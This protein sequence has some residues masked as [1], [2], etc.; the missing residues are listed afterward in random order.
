MLALYNA[1]IHSQSSKYPHATALLIHQGRILAMG[2]DDEVLSMIGGKFTSQNME[3][4]TIWPGLT[5]AHLHLQHYALGLQEVP[6]ETD[7]LEECLQN[8]AH[9]AESTEP[10]KWITGW[11]WNQNV[12]A[13]GYGTAQD[14]DAVAP[15]NPIHL[16]AKS[17]H[18]SWASTAALKLAGI[19]KETPDPEGGSIQR[20]SAGNPTGILFESATELVSSHIPRAKR[21]EIKEA[22]T[23][24]QPE[25]WK[26]GLTGVHDFS[27]LT[28]FSA[29]Q[30]LEQEGVLQLRV[31]KGIPL[32]QMETAIALGL[33]S[34][35][36]SDYVR[37]GSVK[38]F[39]DGALGPQTAAMLT[40]YED[41]TNN[42]G[43]L[44]LT[45][46]QISEYGVR[47]TQN[48]L[49]LA[50]HAIGDRANREVINGYEKIRSFEDENH[51][52]RRRHRIEHVQLL[53]PQDQQRLWQLGIIASMQPIHAT[54]DL[55]IADK[56]WGKRAAGAY[57]FRTLL[58]YGTVLAFG[59]DAPVETP[60][61]FVGL[62]AAVTRRRMDGTPGPEGWHPEQRIRLS[63]AL[64]AYTTGPA[65]A[66]GWEQSSGKLEP[67]YFADLIVLE[68][69]PFSLEPD[70]LYSVKPS[71][72]MIG[73]N[74]VWQS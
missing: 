5:D 42:L 68:T 71:A 35:F 2:S 16:V 15:H 67:G 52:P 18:A 31:V 37:T 19:T 24:V 12:W 23:K 38:V 29:L 11:G 69:D 28:L 27:E 3:D 36:G 55:Y 59:S 63:E 60:N 47:A 48:G 30:E 21:V 70:E 25:M 50:T 22:I 66:A 33:Q 26:M 74:W 14:L 58:D 51:L 10:G 32:E 20:D 57:I 62:H 64:H 54:S 40:P 56:F 17:G 34:G 44:L 45:Q 6:C 39:S 9:R 13:G 61:P 46:E 53:D 49:S 7:T 41:T 8:V 73:G 43:I 1:H 65:Y 4:R 72:T